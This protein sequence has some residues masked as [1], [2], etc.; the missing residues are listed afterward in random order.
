[1]DISRATEIDNLATVLY[2]YGKTIDDNETT[3]APVNNNLIY[4]KDDDAVSLFGWIE[5][6]FR[7]RS[8]ED[9]S[10][11]LER[12]RKELENRLSSTT[13]VKLTA[14]DFGDI[15]MTEYIEVGMLVIAE[16]QDKLL[17]LPC[18]EVDRYFYEPKRTQISLGSTFK[19]LS[20]MIGGFI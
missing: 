7:D 18:T 16:V 11:L 12:G 9:P 17:S 10:L 2:L 4:I 3:V 13:S 14:I 5:D 8:I 6:S 1:M 20:S 15:Q 19:T